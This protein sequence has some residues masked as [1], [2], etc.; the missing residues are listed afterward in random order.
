[1]LLVTP[2]AEGMALKHPLL[3]SYPATWEVGPAEGSKQTWKISLQKYPEQNY[4]SPNLPPPSLWW[5]NLLLPQNK[6]K[7]I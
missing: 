5:H 7:A 4:V 2:Q 3:G 1:M 6:E